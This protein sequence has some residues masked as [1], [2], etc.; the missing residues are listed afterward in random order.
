MPMMELDV[1]LQYVRIQL[2]R[3]I[4]LAYA[5]NIPTIVVKFVH[6]L[7]QTVRPIDGQTL[8]TPA[9]LISALLPLGIPMEIILLI[10]VQQNALILH[11]LTIIQAL[12][13]VS[14]SVRDNTTLW[15]S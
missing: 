2:M 10:L 7:G 13:S 11:G 15:E 3:T 6:M 5:S 12:A 9:A 8:T 1:V 14:Q 4:F